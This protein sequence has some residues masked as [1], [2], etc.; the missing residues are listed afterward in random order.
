MRIENGHV[1]GPEIN[2]TLFALN[3][4]MGNMVSLKKDSIDGVI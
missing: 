4:N 3:L 2:G 1:A